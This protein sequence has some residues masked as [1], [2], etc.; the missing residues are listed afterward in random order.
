MTPSPPEGAVLRLLREA[1]ADPAE[2]ARIF[3]T[4]GR[5]LRPAQMR[6]WLAHP[7]WSHGI[8]DP[9]HADRWGTVVHRTPLS[10]IARGRGDIVLAEAERFAS[11]A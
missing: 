2:A 7:E 1:G 6:D 5:R 4:L 11:A 8:P 10:V 3:A 9:D